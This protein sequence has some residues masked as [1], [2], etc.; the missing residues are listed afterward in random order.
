LRDRLVGG[1]SYSISIRRPAVASERWDCVLNDA[2]DRCEGGI[3]LAAG[4]RCKRLI[5]LSDGGAA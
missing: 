4:A 3:F 1:T 2:A 5:I